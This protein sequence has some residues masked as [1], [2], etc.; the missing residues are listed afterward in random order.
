MTGDA[1]GPEWDE[2]DAVDVVALP[3]E[4]LRETR[5][6][7][8][9][10]TEAVYS[11]GQQHDAARAEA[12]RLLAQSPVLKRVV[13]EGVRALRGEAWFDGYVLA[14]GSGDRDAILTTERQQ[15]EAA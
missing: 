12:E 8:S 2:F 14:L 4:R 9:D 7:A 5:L 6:Y 3:L 10:R 1:F 11:N 15:G 13:L